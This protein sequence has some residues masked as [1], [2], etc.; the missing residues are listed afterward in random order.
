MGTHSEGLRKKL[1][2]LRQLRDHQ[3][4]VKVPRSF[5]LW[6]PVSRTQKPPGGAWA[7]HDPSALALPHLLSTGCSLG[8]GAGAPEPAQAAGTL[9]LLDKDTMVPLCQ[10]QACAHSQPSLP[11]PAPLSCCQ[12]WDPDV[13]RAVL[14]LPGASL[15]SPP[16]T[17]LSSSCSLPP[18]PAWALCQLG[19]G[20]RRWQVLGADP[21][22]GTPGLLLQSSH[23]QDQDL[24]PPNKLLGL[25]GQQGWDTG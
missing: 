2:C 4:P 20:W 9:S 16:T 1:W 18:L 8:S 12:P 24:N 11:S 25:L 14:G 21:T 19:P 3:A 17:S 7:E 5:K 15:L 10:S 23:K 6:G 13:T 22:L